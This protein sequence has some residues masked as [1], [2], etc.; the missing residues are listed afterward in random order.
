MCSGMRN[1]YCLPLA[2]QLESAREEVGENRVIPPLSPPPPPLSLSPSAALQAC[3][4]SGLSYRVV[5]GAS[6]GR[7]LAPVAAAGRINLPSLKC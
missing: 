6:S 5:M 3:L 1:A 7:D 2:R 4:I